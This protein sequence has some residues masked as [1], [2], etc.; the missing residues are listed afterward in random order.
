MSEANSESVK[1]FDLLDARG[2]NEIEYSQQ[3]PKSRVVDANLE[4]TKQCNYQPVDTDDVQCFG[5]F[6]SDCSVSQL[7]ADGQILE[8]KISVNCIGGFRNTTAY[9]GSSAVL[10]V[11]C[12]GQFQQIQDM[13]VYEPVVERL[14]AVEAFTTYEK[15]DTYHTS[16]SCRHLFA[17]SK[18]HDVDA[19][20]EPSLLSGSVGITCDG[21][22]HVQVEKG[23]CSCSK[24]ACAQSHNVM[25]VFTFSA[26]AKQMVRRAN[27]TVNLAEEMNGDTMEAE[28]FRKVAVDNPELARRI[29]HAIVDPVKV[30]R[31]SGVEESDVHPLIWQ[32]HTTENVYVFNGRQDNSRWNSLPSTSWLHVLCNGVS[33]PYACTCRGVLSG[34]VRFGQSGSAFIMCQ[35][36]WNAYEDVAY[37][38]DGVFTEDE[39]DHND[40][41]SYFS[42]I[43]RCDGNLA[44]SPLSSIR[45]DGV[46]YY[47]LSE[48][49]LGAS[50]IQST[51][52]LEAL[53]HRY[54]AHVIDPRTVEQVVCLMA[55]RNCEQLRY[56]T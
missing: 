15:S 24:E 45:E 34:N 49:C 10:N 43:S 6:K 22:Q 30:H 1:H 20:M 14:T 52:A 4:C 8:T 47:G 29:A 53:D 18:T 48:I 55:D 50:T 56:L 2:A 7:F 9:S 42:K 37:V 23:F 41:G 27:V 21:A 36:N 17:V 16:Y 46:K 44:I 33:T 26:S 51:Y 40:F 12:K 11:E 39:S 3:H 19:P 13:A 25:K 35:G 5:S 54:L 31:L 28:N 32:Y 38:C